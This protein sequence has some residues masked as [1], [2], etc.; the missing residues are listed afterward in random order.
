MNLIKNKWF[1]GGIIVLALAWLG[2]MFKD[3]IGP[4][5]GGY[6]TTQSGLKYKFIRGS[7]MKTPPAEG[8]VLLMNYMVIAPDGDTVINNFNATDTFMEAVYP[9]NPDNPILEAI[10]LTGEG[11]TICALIKTDSLKVK[12]PQNSMVLKMPFGKY[13]KFIINVKHVLSPQEFESYNNKKKLDRI[14]IEGRI[15]DAY[16]NSHKDFVW[17]LDTFQHFRY[18]IEGEGKGKNFEPGEEVEF[19]VET[20]GIQKNNLIVHSKMENRKRRIVLGKS[21]LEMPGY[22]VFIPYL[23]EG[24]TAEFAITSRLGFGATGRA[25][26]AAYEPILVKITEINSVKK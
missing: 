23:K 22:E 2:F 15:I 11:S 3:N 16:A 7:K 19:H 5:F 26:I 10:S 1:L 25:G 8:H 24:Q 14:T 9:E 13:A 6:T 17:K 18:H 20:Y 12:F 21:D 4:W